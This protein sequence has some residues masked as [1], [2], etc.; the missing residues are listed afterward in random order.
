MEWLTTIRKS[1]VLRG[2]QSYDPSFLF[3]Q[4][5]DTIIKAGILVVYTWQ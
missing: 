2:I 5:L 4:R 1:R 3:Q